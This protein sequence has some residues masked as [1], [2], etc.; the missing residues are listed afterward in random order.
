MPFN[1]LI[2]LI[3][4]IKPLIF[5]AA[6]AV[7]ALNVTVW[8]CEKLSVK[9]CTDVHKLSILVL[10]VSTSAVNVILYCPSSTLAENSI[11]SFKSF[12]VTLAFDSTFILVFSAF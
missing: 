2:S 12:A 11:K 4:V 9:F 6:W 3:L 5:F 10:A 1:D 7:S 8:A